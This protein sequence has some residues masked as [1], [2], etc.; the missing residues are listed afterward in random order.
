[1]NATTQPK[2][3]L[4]LTVAGML[5]AIWA[6]VAWFFYAPATPLSQAEIDDYMVDV[7]KLL[8]VSFVMPEGVGLEVY[9]AQGA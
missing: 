4:Q 9:P 3:K 5:L 6:V 7:Q 8:E 2:T 1:M